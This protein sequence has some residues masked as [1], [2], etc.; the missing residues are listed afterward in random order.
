MSNLPEITWFIIAVA[1]VL[2]ELALPGVIVVFFGLG[3]GVT[4]LALWLGLIG[5]LDAQLLVFSLSS[6]ALLLSLRR[7]VK[8]RFTGYVPDATSGSSNLDDFT[9][10]TATAMDDLVPGKVGPV[11][12]RGTHWSALSDTPIPKGEDGRIV[13]LEGLTLH[14]TR[15]EG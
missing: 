1:L 9:G 15:K 4:S 14:V 3:A 6:L 2:L 10:G 11:E 12:F 13:K 7:W 8:N 5:S